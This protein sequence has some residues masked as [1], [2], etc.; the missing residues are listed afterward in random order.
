MPNLILRRG[1]DVDIDPKSF[2]VTLRNESEIDAQ[3]RVTYT[4][5]QTIAPIRTTVNVNI[6]SFDSSVY[7]A[8]PGRLVDNV[9]MPEEQS[10]GTANPIG[11]IV[12]F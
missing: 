9:F 2:T 3:V 5:N 7:S 8:P 10:D 12:S 11:I 6:L 1:A 4:D